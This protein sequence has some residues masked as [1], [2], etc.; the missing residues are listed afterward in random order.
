MIYI[1]FFSFIVLVAAMFGALFTHLITTHRREAR[2]FS[3]EIEAAGTAPRR[4][5]RILIAARADRPALASPSPAALPAPPT[6]AATT[7]DLSYVRQQLALDDYAL[8]M[9]SEFHRLNEW[10]RTAIDSIQIT[11]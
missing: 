4:P 10:L 9:E 7:G 2:E 1:L 5:R 11:A 3:A 8:W 6:T